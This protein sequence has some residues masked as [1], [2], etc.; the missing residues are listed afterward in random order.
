MTEALQTLARQAARWATAAQQD[1]NPLI[2]VLHANY[3][4]AYVTALRQIAHD[5][6][7][8]AETGIDPRWL[9]TEIGKIQD[10]AVRA[11]AKTIPHMM[12]R[13]P[14]TRLAGEG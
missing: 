8:S 13:G 12:P 7:I 11:L 14:L 6:L 4:M 2:R 3:A 1:Q 5:Q 10:S 9:E